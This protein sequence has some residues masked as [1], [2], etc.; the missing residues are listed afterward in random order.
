LI[1]RLFTLNKRSLQVVTSVS[2]HQNPREICCFFMTEEE[3]KIQC[4]SPSKQKDNLQPTTIRG[5]DHPATIYVS[6]RDSRAPPGP[7]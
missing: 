3:Q 1:V 6:S 7:N 5:M 4:M 2:L